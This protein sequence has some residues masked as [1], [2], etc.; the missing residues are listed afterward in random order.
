MHHGGCGRY[1]PWVGSHS[2]PRGIEGAPLVTSFGLAPGH[3]RCVAALLLT[4]R[5][6]SGGA[7]PQVQKERFEPLRWLVFSQIDK[8]VDLVVIPSQRLA[9]PPPRLLRSTRERSH[10]DTE[11]NASESSVCCKDDGDAVLGQAYAV[12]LRTRL[13]ENDLLRIH[14]VRSCL[15]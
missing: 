5:L 10:L 15:Q 12:T 7:L 13:G 1:P 9:S 3:P 2:V 6:N 4:I 14:G 8:C 11:P